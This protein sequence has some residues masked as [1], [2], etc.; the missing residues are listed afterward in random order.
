[1]KFFKNLQHVA[2]L[3]LALT[4]CCIQVQ[5]QDEQL[6]RYT[7]NYGFFQISE[8]PTPEEINQLMCAHNEYYTE[9]FQFGLD[10]PTAIYEAQDV[11]W[12]YTP[13]DS[14]PL[15][16]SLSANITALDGAELPSLPN[17]L[18]GEVSIDENFTV[19]IQEYVWP[20][21][22]VWNQMSSINV[23]TTIS[24]PVEGRLK[25]AQCDPNV[26]MAPSTMNETMAP[27]AA[28]G[29]PTMAPSALGNPTVAPSA[30]V[31]G[32]PTVAPTEDP[33][34]TETGTGLF[35][36]VCTITW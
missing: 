6:L 9:R 30:A 14:Q 24:G 33:E 27:S 16:V 13:G 11:D 21:G 8:E 22:G 23:A 26:T 29:N 28:V 12:V 1:M 19:F 2:V 31:V 5:A 15:E 35:V 20:L 3:L 36:S 7:Y 18:S 4:S 32:N 34:V 10:N 25:E 17:I